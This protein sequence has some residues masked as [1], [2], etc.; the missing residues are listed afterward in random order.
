MCADNSKP[1]ESLHCSPELDLHHQCPIIHETPRQRGT[2]QPLKQ[3]FNFFLLLQMKEYKCKVHFSYNKF[4]EEYTS[5][6]WDKLFKLL[7]REEEKSSFDLQWITKK[8][9]FSYLL[10]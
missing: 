7:K 3:S 10:L 8:F 6:F 9:H 2:K 1:Q 4:W 5:N